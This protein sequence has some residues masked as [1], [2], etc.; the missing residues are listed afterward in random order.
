MRPA[1]TD[2]QWVQILW[3]DD[4]CTST[5]FLNLETPTAL[6]YQQTSR[7]IVKSITIISGERGHNK[8]P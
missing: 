6:H 2:P 5:P 4:F 8:I 3:S 7:R 1:P